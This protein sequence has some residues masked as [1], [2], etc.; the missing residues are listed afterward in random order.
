[1]E[2]PTNPEPLPV[3]CDSAD[4]LPRRVKSKSSDNLLSLMML[5][6]ESRARLLWV[7]VLLALPLSLGTETWQ[8]LP[9]PLS[10][11]AVAS[12]KIGDRVVL[13]SFMGIGEKKTHDAITR[14]AFALDTQSGEWSMLPP[15]PGPGRIAASAVGVRGRVYLFGGYTV[16]A[17][18]KEVSLPNVDI[19]DPASHTWSR[20]ADIPVPVD[21]SVAAVYQERYVYLISGWSQTENVRNVQ[22]YDTVTDVWR[23]ATPIAGRPVFGH[24]G[25]L[26]GSTIVYVDGAYTNP[27][28]RTPKYVPSDQ[29][30]MG[31]IDPAD[32]T[33]VQWKR[34]PKHPGSARYRIAAGA[35]S[36]GS[37][38]YFSGGTD[39]PYN[40]NGVGYDRRPAEPVAVTFAWNLQRGRWE[41]VT[42]NTPYPTMDHR[43]LLVTPA[44]LVRV[45][46]ME[47]GQ[48]VTSRVTVMPVR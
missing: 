47:Q 48:R 35:S 12:L 9:T 25:A 31:R 14:S 41:V 13:F 43:G 4:A 24:A 8:S 39:N 30:W 46:G 18:G 11:N 6:Y 23:Q 21:D 33:K 26:L 1:M 29:C 15:V 19:Y 20:G 42:R 22:V 37:R 32:P 27:R 28:G 2:Q 17:D 16:A 7:A 10:N 36:Q 45:G 34:L 3:A 38:I 40:Y 5:N 44:G